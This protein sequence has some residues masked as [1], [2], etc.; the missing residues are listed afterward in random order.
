MVNANEGSAT[1]PDKDK[2]IN[3]VIGTPKGTLPG[4]FEPTDSIANVID[5]A[6]EQKQL[7]G[8]ADAFELYLRNG[9]DKQLLTPV[10]ATLASLGVKSGDKLI[11]AAHG[12]GV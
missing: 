3:V 9:D 10:T 11:L 12:S 5:Y 8:G 2:Q 6:V 7:G 4:R 1:A